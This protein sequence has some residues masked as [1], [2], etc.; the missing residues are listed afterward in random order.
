M[1]DVS[2]GDIIIH[3]VDNSKKA[4]ITGVSFVKSPEILYVKGLPNSPWDEKIDCHMHMLENYIELAEPL[5]IYDNLLTE[6]N[7]PELDQSREDQEASFYTKKDKLREGGYL[8][9]CSNT[10]V[11]VINRVCMEINNHPLPH[12]VLQSTENRPDLK[13]AQNE[14]GGNVN[15]GP[16]WP[17][18][19]FVFGGNRP[20][21]SCKHPDY[22]QEAVDLWTNLMKAHGIKRVAFL[23]H[24]DKH[25]GRYDH[26]EGGLKGQ[27]E[28][29]FGAEN[30]LMVPIPDFD[31]AT[32]DQIIQLTNFF[33]ESES[34]KL[35]VVVHCS[36][37]SGRTGHVL[38]VW[39]KNRWNL[40]R[41][42][43]LSQR[44]FGPA[45]R[46]PKE[47]VGEPSKHLGRLI[48]TSDLYHLM[49][50]VESQEESTQE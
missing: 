17:T 12:L 27:Y 48:D 16:S 38:A 32:E 24:P 30:V 40:E 42:E 47:S 2:K 46:Y 4:R 21:K 13:S 50:A 23:L 37:G 9:P 11:S 6:K 10:L 1:R 45:H 39:R 28:S 8:T 20:G 5:L 31:I 33:A 44:G 14:Y 7:K 25:L 22:S 26:L 41:N 3:V 19:Q 49:H 34:L 36:A 18:D 29:K 15:F 43:S 35:P